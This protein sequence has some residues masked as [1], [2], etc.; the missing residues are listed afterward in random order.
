[1]SWKGWTEAEKEAFDEE[2]RQ[3]EASRP[4]SQTEIYL[5]KKDEN[6]VSP[7]DRF[8]AAYAQNA[9]KNPDGSEFTGYKRD[10]T[11]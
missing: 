1:M 6:G 8:K 5:N 7:N 3:E 9:N 10:K 11:D 4:P 2:R